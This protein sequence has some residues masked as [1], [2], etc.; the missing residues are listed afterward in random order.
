MIMNTKIEK[1]LKELEWTGYQ[2]GQGYGYMGSGNDGPVFPACPI[3]NGI[4]PKSGAEREFD[5]S[6][7]GHQPRCR[8]KSVLK[9]IE[10]E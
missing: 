7:I 5:S 1:L 9:S 4:K 6:A 2:Q 3:C 10:K 8:M